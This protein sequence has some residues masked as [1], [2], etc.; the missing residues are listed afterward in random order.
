MAKTPP[1][2]KFGVAAAVLPTLPD[3]E[4]T[5]EET[6][7]MTLPIVKQTETRTVATM[8][9]TIPKSQPTSNRPTHEQ[10]KPLHPKPKPL[11]P[12]HPSIHMRHETSQPPRYHQA[13]PLQ[14][15]RHDDSRSVHPKYDD[16]RPLQSKHDSFGQTQIGNRKQID[17]RSRPTLQRKRSSIEE[18]EENEKPSEPVS[19]FMT[20]YDKMIINNQKKNGGDAAPSRGQVD[21][22]KKNLGTSK[23]R[24]FV[25]PLLSNKEKQGETSGQKT[26][27]NG[28]GSGG[29]GEEIDE[30]LRNI[31]PKMIEAIMNEIMERG[32]PVSW[33]DIA[34]VVVWPMLRPDIFT[35]IRGPPKGLLLFGPPGKTLIG[36]CIA[37][38]SGATFF[39]I[40]SSSLT[41]K[42]VG[43]GWR[44]NGS[45]ALA[46]A[47][48]HQPSVIFVDEIDSLLTQRTDGEV[49]ATRRIKTEFLVQFDGCGTDS[50]DRIL[51]IG[52]LSFY[53]LN[54]TVVPH[55]I[56]E[57]ARRRFRKKLYIPLPE[58]P[59]RH[60]IISHLL[61][62]Q[63]HGLTEEEVQEIVKSTD[64]Y[65]GSDVD[66]LVREA[67]L[68]P[69]R[70]IRDIQNISVND[71]RPITFFDFTEASR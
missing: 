69:I 2:S 22:S 68:G 14:T 45:S 33:D 58:A 53:S 63:T 42:W 25:S 55:E 1:F 66:G 34:E 44:E 64:G 59:A 15:Q 47:R 41:S 5:K 7:Q 8:T 52:I 50:E 49:E 62:K 39:S 11:E 67:A 16:N 31:D 35:G 29:D 48:V 30:R 6:P 17:D 3:F 10:D 70:D 36:K 61:S 27:R 57:A 37:S 60:H 71:V 9:D 4:G 46:V 12:T 51:L 13:P 23:R 43:W 28:K 26:N 21:A 40:S 54:L 65:S 19:S 24:K 32:R 20:A 38:Q 56:D 18:D